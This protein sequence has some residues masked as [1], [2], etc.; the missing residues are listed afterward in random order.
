[1]TWLRDA[2]D[3]GATFMQGAEVERILF[4]DPDRPVLP[5]AENFEQLS[6]SG[7]RR[8]AVGALVRLADGKRAIVRARKSVVVSGGSINTPA[9][10]LRSGLKGPYIGRGL[11]LHPATVVIA[12]FD[13]EMKPWDGAILTTVSVRR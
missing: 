10:L 8:K 9:T 11:K 13:E 3:L 6:P 1:M 5:N 4:S 12:Y 7:Q 2:S